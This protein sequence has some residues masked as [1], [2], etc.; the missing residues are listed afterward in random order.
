MPRKTLA[1]VSIIRVSQSAPAEPCELTACYGVTYFRRARHRLAA[2]RPCFD[3][4]RRTI[5]CH[6]YVAIQV[7]TIN[8]RYHLGQAIIGR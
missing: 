8:T 7:G 6:R 5:G 4:V 3:I 2:R 1:I